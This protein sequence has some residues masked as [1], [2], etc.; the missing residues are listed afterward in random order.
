MA[1][2]EDWDDHIPGPG[3]GD[4]IGHCDLFWTNVIFRSGLPVALI[5][6]E[7]AAPTTR[8]LELALA[9]TYWAGLRVDRQLLE[10]GLPLDRRGERLRLLC[11]SY[12]LAAEGRAGLLAELLAQRRS[13]LERGDWRVV[14]RD[15]IAEN[16][17]W[18]E[19]HHDELARFLA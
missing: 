5:D 6:W 13:R 12:G 11:D 1:P 4:V 7:L 14:G 16:L 19:E 9:A 2:V 3:G 17:R 15:V 8:V 10:W 18:L